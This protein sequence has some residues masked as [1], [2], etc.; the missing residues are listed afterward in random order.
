MLLVLLTIYIND[1]QFEQVIKEINRHSNV[2]YDEYGRAH[3]KE[4][5]YSSKAKDH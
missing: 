4:S 1:E 2:S 5:K 3:R